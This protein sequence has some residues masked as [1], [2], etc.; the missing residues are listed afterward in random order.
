MNKF[1][2]KNLFS[3]RHWNVLFKT[4]Y[5]SLKSHA[6]RTFLASLGIVI[7]TAAVI[8]VFAAGE[9]ITGLITDQ[10]D[11]FGSNIIE[12]EIKMPS[13]KQGMAADI[14]MAVAMAGGAQVT[15][16]KIADMDAINNLP[17]IA[18]SYAGVMGQE[19][20]IAGDEDRKAFLMAVS[21]D[22]LVIDKGRIGDGR[23]FDNADDKSLA[24]VAVLG[25]SMKQK[26]FGDTDAIGKS[27]KI[28]NQKFQVIGVM[29]ERGAVMTLNFDDMIYVP[30][31]TAQKR[32][33]GINYVSFIMH[34]VI[35]MDMVDVTADDIRLVMRDRHN[36]IGDIGKEDFRITSIQTATQ[37]MDDVM[38][39]LS[40]LLV[41][42]VSVSLLVGGV[43]IMNIMF[44]SVNER[45]A[46][47]GLRKAIGARFSDI[48]GLFLLEA[49]MK[50]LIGALAGVLIGSIIAFMIAVGAGF[51]GLV[52]PFLIPLKAF[53]ISIG[54]AVA[55]GVLFGVYPAI[56]A[57][58]LNPVEALRR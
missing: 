26:L 38:G 1:L 46:E 42:I 49:I 45:T 24:R 8:V 28:R 18:K 44:I 50:T 57:A 25:S 2:D 54:F 51:A 20:V 5:E 9:G 35:D 48:A 47:I 12:T 34:E 40:L 27:I 43:G 7:S 31:R 14:D 19:R 58:K 32:I 56:K 17:N 52:W 3:G 11:F 22:F 53:M 36:I 30:L 23:F 16:L 13:G 29:E 41:A 21:G 33:L 55:C 39:G 37:V 10:F 15:T 4:A 6:L